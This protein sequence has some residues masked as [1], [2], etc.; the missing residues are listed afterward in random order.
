MMITAAT[1]ASIA[2]EIERMARYEPK[3]IPSGAE[4]V[5]A[6]CNPV[7]TSS[8]SGRFLVALAPQKILP[9][10]FSF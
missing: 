10:A 6:D 7:S 2:C 4:V 3:A 8:A 1:A 5:I 9:R